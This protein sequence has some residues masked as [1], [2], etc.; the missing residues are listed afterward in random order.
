MLVRRGPYR[1]HGDPKFEGQDE[2]CFNLA[3]DID[4]PSE[5]D[6][7]R[8]E[9]R[10]WFDEHPEPTAAD[11]VEAGYVVPHWPRPWGLDA[12][13]ELQLIIDDEI[14]RAG[15]AKPMN[16]IGIGH[17]G[18]VIVVH[19][20]DEQQQR[21]LPPMLRGE[22]LWC[23]LFSEPEAGSDLANLSTRAVRDGDVFVVNGQKI[24]TSLAQVA[25]FGI[26]IARTDP[27][28]SKYTGISYFIVPMDLPGIEIRPLRNMVGTFGDAGF[29]EVFFTD[30]HVPA[31]NLIGSLNGGWSMA[32]ET[33]ANERVSLSREGLQWGHGPT[34]R[35]LLD[36][37][38]KRGGAR[39]P[40]LR[41]QLADAYIEGEI[42]RYHQLRQ[43]SAKVNKKPGPD[44]SLRK[45]LKDPH[46]K[47]VFML[48]KD[49]MGAEGMLAI[50]DLD[51]SWD[52]WAAG[53][54]FSPALTVGGGT[55]EVLRNIIA[56]RL[57]GLPHDTDVEAGLTWAEAHASGRSPR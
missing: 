46:G 39:D 27:D 25:K 21:Y 17:C 30:V 3:V 53:F 10:A 29:C 16:P 13:P 33:L 6:P 2:T 14:K 31:A 23:Q 19:G 52:P 51:A 34:V 44:A 49:M 26:L 42:M 41:Q 15:V 18:P 48:A 32:K 4:L 45:A 9:V 56:E 47:R 12:E 57:L 37:L 50:G 1:G 20:T 8:L 24:W 55:A 40:M 43:I 7:R 28:T 35:D 38:R 36:L 5:D 22:E 11:L 54:L